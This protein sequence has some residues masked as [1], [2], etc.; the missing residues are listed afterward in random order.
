MSQES[1]VADSTSFAPPAPL[2]F[3]RRSSDRWSSPGAATAFRLGGRDFGRMHELKLIDFSHHGLGA[4][5]PTVIEPGTAVS[6]GFQAPGCIARRGTVLRCTPCGDGYRV[7]V[8]FE[9]RMA[10]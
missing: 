1:S 7:A 3:E 9:M 6:I 2:R 5:S 4:I 10:A 8:E